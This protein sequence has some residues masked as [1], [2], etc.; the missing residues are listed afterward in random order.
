M[1]VQFIDDTYF[2]VRTSRWLFIRENWLPL[3]RVAFASQGKSSL[4]RY[5]QNSRE[6]RLYHITQAREWVAM[7]TVESVH[8]VLSITSVLN[9]FLPISHFSQCLTPSANCQIWSQYSAWPNFS[10]ISANIPT[11]YALPSIQP[12]PHWEAQWTGKS[13]PPFGGWLSCVF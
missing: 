4:Y 7:S 10:L 12:P 6:T 8:W 3:R 11:N 1:N 9:R 5:L 2:I 13:V